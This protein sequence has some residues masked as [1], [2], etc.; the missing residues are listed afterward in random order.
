MVFILKTRKNCFT[1]RG[2]PSKEGFLGLEITIVPRTSWD[3]F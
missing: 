3:Q 2:V 1:L